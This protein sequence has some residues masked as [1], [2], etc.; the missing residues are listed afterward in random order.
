MTEQLI[1]QA[2]SKNIKAPKYHNMVD[3]GYAS[4]LRSNVIKFAGQSL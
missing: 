3:E 1:K 2:G 4:N